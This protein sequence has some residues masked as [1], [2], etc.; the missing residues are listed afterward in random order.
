MSAPLRSL[1]Q[2]ADILIVV[3][4]TPEDPYNYRLTAIASAGIWASELLSAFLA[5]QLC[6]FVHSVDVTNAGLN[7]IRNYPELMPALCW[8]S[9]HVLRWV[10]TMLPESER[11][12]TWSGLQ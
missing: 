6:Y 4:A 12:L 1:D 5:R 7:E 10:F 2:G 3:T 8:C 11:E 9:I